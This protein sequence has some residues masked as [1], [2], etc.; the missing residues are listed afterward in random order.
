MANAPLLAAAALSGGMDSLMALVLLR[1][2]GY[3]VMG[4]HAHF[5]PPDEEGRR[6][7]EAIAARCGELDV[8]FHAVDLSADFER[9]VIRP[10]IEAYA[11]GETPNPCAH[12]N[13]HMKFGLLQDMAFAL[14][15]DVLATG[16]FAR[17]VREDDGRV[18]LARGADPV[19]DQSY[20]LTLVPQT[21]LERAAF[22]L[23]DWR[24]ADIPA[25]LAAHGLT[26][27][28]P[29]PSLEVCFIPGDDYRAFLLER[30]TKLSGPGPIRLAD[31]VEV[32]RH[33]GLWRHTIGQRK[34]LGVAWKE[35]LY[36][37]GK[38]VA[39]N[40]LIVGPKD[41][42]MTDCCLAGEVN[43]LSPP[44]DWPG[45]LAAQTCYRQRPRP[46]KAVYGKDGL[47]RL[48]FDDPLPRPTPGQVAAVFD[49][50]GNA[51]AGG[52]IR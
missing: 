32:G 11:R 13:R 9:L 2:Q 10:F 50:M 21:R 46:V 22:P 18:H 36:V 43:L 39:R 35:P 3:A 41:A 52:L 8:P 47:L 33:Q 37:L 4:L 7:A 12:C 26:P 49:L 27:P 6:L 20:F 48:R 44:E 23:C 1:E 28:L 51:K 25:A 5:L 17:L 24:K 15:A 19:K 14:G 45:E 38:D 31:G 34:G 40:A 42:L 16:H 30:G 29:R